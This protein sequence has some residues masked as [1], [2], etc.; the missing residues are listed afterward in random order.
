MTQGGDPAVERVTYEEPTWVDYL[1]LYPLIPIGLVTITCRLFWFMIRSPI[2]SALKVLNPPTPRELID[3]AF[4]VLQER[5]HAHGFCRDGR[6]RQLVR[7]R[8]G[9]TERIGYSAGKYNV[10]GGTAEFGV[11][12]EVTAPSHPFSLTWRSGE[13]ALWDENTGGLNIVVCLEQLWL[14]P[15]VIDPYRSYFDMYPRFLRSARTQKAAKLTEKLG[16]RWFE[17]DRA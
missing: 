2:R 13:N 5:M 12:F 14:I 9:R 11:W 1:T 6:K 4:V 16:L 10:S 3:N 7:H 15:D 8:N 17:I